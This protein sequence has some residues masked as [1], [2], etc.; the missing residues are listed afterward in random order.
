MARIPID[1]YFSGF[2]T[3]FQLDFEIIH[4][5]SLGYD[6][7]FHC[8]QGQGLLFSR[9][10]DRLWKHTQPRIQEILRIISPGVKRPKRESDQLP[11][12]G[13]KV[14]NEWSYMFAPPTNL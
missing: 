6:P 1:T 3:S 11:P 4:S 5:L 10:P 9:S 7:G 2:P 13:V 14:K 8:R 12:S